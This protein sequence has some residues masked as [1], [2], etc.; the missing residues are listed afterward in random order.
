MPRCLPSD[1]KCE[2][3][4]QPLA[5]DF[6]LRGP[7]PRFHPACADLRKFL[8]AAE[9]ALKLVNFS[10]ASPDIRHAW[11]RRLVIMLNRIPP[12]WHAVRGADGRFAR[13]P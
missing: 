2:L 7:L 10:A 1:L 12:D 3:C 5:L 4:G 8:A 11:R 13:K 9:A 6:G